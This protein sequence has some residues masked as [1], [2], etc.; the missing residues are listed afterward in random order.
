M[1][2][3]TDVSSPEFPDLN[4]MDHDQRQALLL[5]LLSGNG[6]AGVS[7]SVAAAPMIVTPQSVA[8]ETPAIRP[9]HGSLPQNASGRPLLLA[10]TAV[11]T[12]ST[13]PSS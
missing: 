13:V 1:Q 4:R 10:P 6:S 12:P 5:A 2:P 8:T 3:N 11:S 7:P 9:Y